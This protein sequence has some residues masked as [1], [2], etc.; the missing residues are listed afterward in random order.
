MLYLRLHIFYYD[1]GSYTLQLKVNQYKFS[2]LRNSSGFKI[3][4]ITPLLKFTNPTESSMS[5][6]GVT[7]AA[8]TYVKS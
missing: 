3:F 4:A 6:H 5:Y 1:K 7:Y 2:T 8:T